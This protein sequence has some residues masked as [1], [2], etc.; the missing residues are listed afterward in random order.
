[1]DHVPTRQYYE[2]M[3]AIIDFIARTELEPDRGRLL[4]LDVLEVGTAWGISGRAFV[5]HP[6]VK[7]LT[8][9]DPLHNARD[10]AKGVNEIMLAQH[11][12][13]MVTLMT[14]RNQTALPKLFEDQKQFD[15]VYIDGSHDYRDVAF[16]TE[17]CERLSKRWII[18][19]DFLHIKN[20]DPGK[21]GDYYGVIRAV[22]EMLLNSGYQAVIWPTK[23]NGTLVID[24]GI[25]NKAL[26]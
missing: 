2:T 14:E 23:V 22:R 12:P 1:M 15:V 3:K 17:W 9:I 13:G 19:D 7:S 4:E 11:T 18:F 21:D 16:D 25:K 6:S 24:K 5:E 8:T 10:C 26:W 20:L